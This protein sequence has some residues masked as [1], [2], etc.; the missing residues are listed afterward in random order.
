MT[1]VTGSGRIPFRR[2]NLTGGLANW[3]Y[4]L[5]HDTAFRRVP[6]FLIMAIS[7]S[8][9]RRF[10]KFLVAVPVGADSLFQANQN[11]GQFFHKQDLNKAYLLYS[12]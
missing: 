12:K 6:Y 7:S 2:Y 11:V 10:F 1:S 9:R 5:R 3:P 8:S 4:Q